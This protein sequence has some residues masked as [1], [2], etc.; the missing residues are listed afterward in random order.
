MGVEKILVPMDFSE[1]A[2]QAFHYALMLRQKYGG[3]I[4]LLHVLSKAFEVYLEAGERR[5]VVSGY[6]FGIDEGIFTYV[7]PAGKE[8]RR[9]LR[10]EAHA[11]LQELIPASLQQHIHTQV[12]IGDPAQEILATV[13]EHGVDLIVM[14]THGR[15]GLSHLWL[16]SVAERV[17]RLSPIPVLTLRPAEKASE[18]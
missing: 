1:H 14:G 11:K 15:T 5:F 4:I 17:V 10:E 9:D 2:Q 6:E 16:G 8:I 18:G 13:R 7:N 12:K 3:E